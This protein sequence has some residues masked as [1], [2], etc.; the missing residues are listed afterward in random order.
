[1]NAL[2]HSAWRI[3]SGG[4]IFFKDLVV[5]FAATK[6]YGVFHWKVPGYYGDVVLDIF[7]MAFRV[8]SVILDQMYKK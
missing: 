7:N 5:K 6:L 2:T 3:H 4:E 8:E 1:M